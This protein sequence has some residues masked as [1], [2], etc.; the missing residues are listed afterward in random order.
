MDFVT[1]KKAARLLPPDISVIMRGKH[2]IGKCLKHDTVMVDPGTGRQLHLSDVVNRKKETLFKDLQGN[3]RITTPSN[4]I[5]SGIKK[6]FIL[7]TRS[8][9]EI[10]ATLDHRFMTVDGWKKLKDL[11][12]GD[13]VETIKT[14]PEPKNKTNPCSSEIYLIAG[15]LSEGNYTQPSTVRFTNSD[16]EI[17]DIIKTSAEYI[18]AEM[19]NHPSCDDIEYHFQ[20][21]KGK[22]R[23]RPNPVRQLLNEYDCKNE[24]AIEKKIPEKVFQYSNDSLAKFIGM[25]WSCDGTITNGNA[26]ICLGSKKML[27][28]IQH[29]LLRFGI[30]SRIRY[31]KVKYKNSYRDAWDLRVYSSCL[32]DFK[33]KIPLYG[34][35]KNRKIKIGCNPNYDTVP[36]TPNLKQTILE[37]I[38][39]GKSQGLKLKDIGKQIGWKSKFTSNYLL[40]TKTMSKRVF[41]AFC[42]IFDIKDQIKSLSK[43]N[44]D[45]IV[46]IEYDGEHQT[47]DLTIDEFHNFVANDFIVHNSEVVRQL[48]EDFN[49]PIVERR[50]SQ[51]TE[52]DLIGLPFNHENRAT[53]FL[54]PSWFV[55]AIDKPYLIFL[56]EFDRAIRE[57]QQAAMELILERSIQ[58]AVIH[59]DCRVYSAI[60]GG[61]HGSMYQVN[62]I[63]PAINDRFWIADCDPS[64]GEWIIW[65]KDN[66]VIKEI[67]SFI[68]TNEN[69]LENDLKKDTYKITPSRRSWTR[70]S[71][72]LATHPEI[73]SNMISRKGSSL[74]TAICSGFVGTEST[75]R[76]KGF[77]TNPEHHIFVEDILDR[78]DEN[79]EKFENFR[80]E[81]LNL[82]IDKVAD[83]TRDDKK[84]KWTLDQVKNVNKFFRSLSPELRMTMWDKIT[85][86]DSKLENAQLLSPFV[87]DLIIGIVS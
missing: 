53:K 12:V 31:K 77:I 20:W 86:T 81:H 72:V 30:F 42:E 67:T 5:N 41:D 6:C 32:K 66:K 13:Y 79:K 83:H 82:A 75:G 69:A 49:I 55:D 73:I 62:N 52:G 87:S 50:L 40:K 11:S 85:T 8:G 71:R 3:I 37:I 33:E 29:L 84:D 23:R 65:A 47:Y 38:E 14:L 17:I 10:S 35:K 19:I 26:E 60:N 76:F 80:I 1:F 25:F 4:S 18:D 21:P 9:K 63:D 46:S 7:K 57:V 48:G 34:D 16:K 58:G 68:E 44:W 36:L 54:P 51:L 22:K 39:T 28:Q 70:L 64:V 24:K 61:K 2:G 56:D 15:L 74:F 27:Y 59:P 78:F 45:E 43:N